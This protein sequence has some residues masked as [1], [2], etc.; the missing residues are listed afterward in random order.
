M[1]GLCEISLGFGAG[2][3]TENDIQQRCFTNS[4]IIFRKLV[5]KYDSSLI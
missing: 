4:E 5:K 2:E 1:G 3:S